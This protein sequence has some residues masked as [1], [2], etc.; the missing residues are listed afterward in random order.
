[1]AIT[2]LTKKPS[3]ADDFI[4]AAPDAAADAPQVKQPK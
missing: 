3:A 2:K 1:M 4:A